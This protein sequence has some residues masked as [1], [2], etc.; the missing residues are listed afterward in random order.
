MKYTAMMLIGLF[1]ATL[2]ASAHAYVIKG[3][4]PQGGGRSNPNYSRWLWAQKQSAARQQWLIHHG[5]TT[6]PSEAQGRALRSIN[7]A[8][9]NCNSGY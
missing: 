4:Y 2:S 5:V 8:G 3:A 7:S 9:P 1:A 6:L